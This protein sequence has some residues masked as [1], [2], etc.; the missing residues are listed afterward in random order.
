MPASH[1]TRP[2]YLPA[3]RRM[4]IAMR[5]SGVL[6]DA[7]GRA[8]TDAF[9]AGLGLDPHD[10]DD[11]EEADYRALRAAADEALAR[12]GSGAR[13]VVA[14]R[15]GAD[16]V[17]DTGMPDDGRVRIGEVRWAQVSALFVDEPAA[18]P[19]VNRARA[20]LAAGDAAGARNILDEQELLW[21]APG[22][23]DDIE[24]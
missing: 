2:V 23:L 22:E 20:D 18:V 1:E 16:R 3:D 15:V 8:A 14:A 17:T 11:A 24:G 7:E 13:W 21:Y 5:D 19:V 9:A 4:V 6:V 12:G 10:R